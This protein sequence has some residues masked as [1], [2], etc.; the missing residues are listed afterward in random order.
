MALT[1]I[2]INL[3]RFKKFWLFLWETLSYKIQKI[4]FINNFFITDKY[5]P[6]NFALRDK[7]E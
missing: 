6:L 2:H 7:K 1:Y 5:F 4:D 3:K